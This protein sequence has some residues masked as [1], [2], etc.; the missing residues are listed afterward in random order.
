MLPQSFY[1][2]LSAARLLTR[3]IGEDSYPK[4]WWSRKVTNWELR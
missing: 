2:Y 4:S 3:R 1:V